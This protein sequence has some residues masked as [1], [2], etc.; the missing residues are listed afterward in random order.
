M[1]LHHTIPHVLVFNLVSDL[2]AYRPDLAAYLL[3][4]L[5]RDVPPESLFLCVVDPGVGGERSAVAALIDDRWYVGPDNGLLSIAL[6]RAGQV[7][8]WR[9]DWRPSKLSSSFHGRD[10]FAPVAAHIALEGRVIGTPMTP[11][12]LVGADWSDDCHKVVY[13][14]LYGN[15]CIGTRAEAVDRRSTIKAGNQ[16]L[17]FSR[18][19][20][21]VPV[22]TAFW[23][24][25][26]FGLIELAVNQGRA[27]CALGL[28]V[29]DSI[30]LIN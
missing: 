16:T 19:F 14:D 26:A 3:P 7:E 30:T 20:C 6:R 2:P 1:V 17:G 9:V 24:E 12:E 5:V 25:N 15:L 11:G 29:G 13:G 18:T 22:G 21:E 23:Y 4:Q 28:E 10:L 8:C 27:D